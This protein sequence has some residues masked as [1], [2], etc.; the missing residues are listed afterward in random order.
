MNWYRSP[1]DKS[2]GI[3]KKRDDQIDVEFAREK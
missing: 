1:I 3:V 2:L